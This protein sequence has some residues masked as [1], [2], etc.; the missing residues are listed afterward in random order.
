MLNT[1][2]KAT[3]N[4][5]GIFLSEMPVFSQSVK[6]AFLL[7]S[8]D[9]ATDQNLTCLKPT[10]TNTVSES[11]LNM[12]LNIL[13]GEWSAEADATRVPWLMKKKINSSLE[14]SSFKQN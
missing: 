5:V 10:E 9:P 7:I 2:P 6:T 4:I 8:S 3:D 12:T 14:N 1:C 11:G 13:C